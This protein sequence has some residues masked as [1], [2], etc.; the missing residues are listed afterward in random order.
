MWTTEYADF[1]ALY[2]VPSY[3]YTESIF[4]RK[5]AVAIKTNIY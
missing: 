2:D 3:M 4:F 5:S 1:L